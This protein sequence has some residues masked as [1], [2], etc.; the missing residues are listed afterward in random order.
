MYD[1]TLRPLKD[2]LFDPLSHRIPARISPTHITAAAFALGAAACLA[3]AL[4]RPRTAL[5]LWLANRALDCLDGAVAR[6]R[7]QASDLGGFLDLLGDFVVYA[8]VPVCCALGAGGGEK[9]W[10]AVAVVE[11]GFFLNNFVLFFGAAVAERRRAEGARGVAGA[12]TA[13]EE[14]LTSV[15]M[16][17]ALVEGLESGVAFTLMLAWPRY[18]EMWCWV[19]AAGVAVGTVQRVTW[20]VR[21]LKA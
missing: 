13:S 19:L 5:A 17:P 6:Y 3:A 9:V 15:S 8:A 12:S 2:R 4:S 10:R 7:S 18:T 14:E 20:T 16:R 1:L 11:A 21:A